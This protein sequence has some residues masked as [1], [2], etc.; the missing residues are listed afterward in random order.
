MKD[1][2]Q[3]DPLDVDRRTFLKNGMLAVGTATAVAALSTDRL[4]AATEDVGDVGPAIT[5][6][7]VA[8]LKFL[9][10]AE[11]LES[12]LWQQYNELTGVGAADSGYKAALNVLDMDMPQYV[13]DNTDD[14]ISHEAFLNA[15][16]VAK[17]AS[18]EQV[19]SNLIMPE[20]CQ[21]LSRKF[22]VCSIVRPTAIN[23]VAMGAVRALT[24][25]GLFIGQ[26]H[27]FFEVLRDLAED[28]DR[29]RRTLWSSGRTQ[30]AANRHGNLNLSLHC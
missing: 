24:N 4:V 23:G 14:E 28:A 8:I 11:I 29:A 10:A 6:G 3:G 16:L 12:D 25:D 5:S 22:P 18:G 13:S 2:Q 20:P 9:A 15:Y 21:F 17:G 30:I 1:S 19:K 27:E 7:D 26:G